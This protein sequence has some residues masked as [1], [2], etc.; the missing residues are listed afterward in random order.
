MY[1]GFRV[2]PIESWKVNVSE[3]T[4]EQEAAPSVVRMSL[5]AVSAQ[6]SIT[7]LGAGTSIILNRTLG[8]EGRGD[9]ALVQLWPLLLSGLASAGWTSALG[10]CI[11]RQP[12]LKRPFWSAAQVSGLAVSALVC[13]AGFAAIPWLM[14][15]AP[16]LWELAR[17]FLLTIPLTFLAQS[18]VAGLEALQRYDLS[19]RVRVGNLIG[20][21]SFLIPLA[22]CRQLTP[23]TYCAAVV[24]TSAATMAYGNWLFARISSGPWEPRWGP[25]PAFVLRSSPLGWMQTLQLRVDQF[26][27]ALLAPLDPTAFGAYVVGTTLAGMVSP[28]AQGLAL[29]LLPESARRGEAD[30]VRLFARMG[31]L[32]VLAALMVGL[33]A[34]LAA[35]W[36]LSLLYG[37]GFGVGAYALRIGLLS[38]ILSG[39][40]TMGLNMI[41]GAGRPGTATTLGIVSG[42]VSLAGSALLLPVLGYIGAALGQTVGL[43][44]GLILLSVVYRREG[45][46]LLELAPRGADARALWNGLAGVFRRGAAP[47][48]GLPVPLRGRGA[49]GEG[50][51]ADPA[52][53]R[54]EP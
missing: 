17:W 22:L 2:L 42:L 24:I 52:L 51:T 16:E 37:P 44:A 25:L 29:V 30:A 49:G 12:E 33:P 35:P 15:D 7:L 8:P 27:I 23:A 43:L 11:S 46:T 39:V 20:H 41:Q 4:S 45:L 5:W 1:F 31:R 50:T 53:V 38:A 34:A 36:L 21:L 14:S 54:G 9:V 3:R 26:V 40:F 13:L 10:S 48:D 6:M 47:T 18:A 32:F 28:I 19:S